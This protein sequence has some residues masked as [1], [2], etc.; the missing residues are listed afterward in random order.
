[1]GPQTS[2]HLLRIKPGSREYCRPTGIN[3]KVMSG[4]AVIREEWCYAFG[5]P[6]AG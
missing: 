3:G 5:N 1:M 2:P 6:A 4:W